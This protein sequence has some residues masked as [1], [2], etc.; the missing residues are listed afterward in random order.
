MISFPQFLLESSI[1][2]LAFYLFYY[3][4]LRKE[5]F[6]Q[7]NRLFLLS[8]PF[9]AIAIPLLNINLQQNTLESTSNS[10]DRML[11]PAVQQVQSVNSFIWQNISQ[12]TAAFSLS[13]GELLLIFYFIGVGI[14]LIR[15]VLGM[16]R[17]FKLI[18]KNKQLK[19]K[20]YTVV[21][22][23]QQFPAA[24][25]FSYIFWN[26]QHIPDDKKLIFEHELVHVRQF[27]SLDVLLMEC[28]VI[29][30]WYNPLIYLYRNALQTTHEYIADQY[31]SQKASSVYQYASLLLQH[32]QDQSCTPLLNTFA[33]LIKKRLVML[34][35]SK[36]KWYRSLKYCWSIPLFGV[37]MLLF[38]FNLVDEIPKNSL[39]NSL[40]AIEHYL[41]DLGD[42]TVLS[43]EKNHPYQPVLEWGGVEFGLTK[44]ANDRSLDFE[45]KTISANAFQQISTQPFLI[46]KLYET[47]PILSFEAVIETSDHKLFSYRNEFSTL[48]EATSKL[49]TDFTLYLK[50]LDS[51]GET[52]YS[53]LSIG[54]TFGLY[55]DQ[56]NQNYFFNQPTYF[57][58]T[59]SDYIK[60]K[61]LQNVGQN[62]Y[63]LE[64]SDKKFQAIKSGNPMKEPF[65]IQS[66][67]LSEFEQL[68]NENFNLVYNNS[69]LLIDS[70]Y[71]MVTNETGTQYKCKDQWN[72]L[73]CNRNFLYEIKQDATVYL[74]IRTKLGDL[75][76]SIISVGN[77]PTLYLEDEQFYSEMQKYTHF[78]NANPQVEKLPTDD[79]QL[80]WGDLSIQLSKESSKKSISGQTEITRSQFLKSLKK[81][82]V[83][84]LVKG[85]LFDQL[86]FNI[87]LHS[88]KMN[89][90]FSVGNLSSSS[91][92]SAYFDNALLKEIEN[93]IQ[94]IDKINLNQIR[95]TDLEQ[96][97]INAT[98]FLK[99]DPIYETRKISKRN[100]YF[101]FHWGLMDVHLTNESQK[102]FKATMEISKTDFQKS[103]TQSPVLTSSKKGVFNKFGFDLSC[104]NEK[105]SV[106]STLNY[107]DDYTN[108]LDVDQVI[109]TVKVGDTFLLKK[110]T[111]NSLEEE[112][113]LKIIITEPTALNLKTEK[114]QDRMVLDWSGF[115]F[116]LR[117]LN[118]GNRTPTKT[119]PITL[120]PYFF[121]S[122]V[123]DQPMLFHK[124][125]LNTIV[126]A[127]VVIKDGEL[128]EHAKTNDWEH[129]DEIISLLEYA[130]EESQISLFFKTKEKNNYILQ[131]R[132]SE[133]LVDETILFG[134]DST[135]IFNHLVQDY[136]KNT[137]KSEQ[138]RMQ[139][140]TKLKLPFSGKKVEVIWGTNTYLMEERNNSFGHRLD[141]YISLNEL[142]AQLNQPVQFKADNKI[143]TPA[144]IHLFGY[145]QTAKE[146][147][148]Y[149]LTNNDNEFIFSTTDKQD[150][151]KNAANSGQIHL[152]FSFKNLDLGKDAVPIGIASISFSFSGSTNDWKPTI[153]TQKFDA[154]G[155][156]FPFQMV[157]RT[158]RHTLVR[159]DTTSKKYDW[160]VKSYQNNPAVDLIHI[161]GFKTHQRVISNSGIT[162]LKKEDI[163][164]QEILNKDALNPMIYPDYYDFGVKY[165][166]LFWRDFKASSFDT[167]I[168]CLEDFKKA[169]GK[170]ELHIDDI[171]HKI[172]QFDL[173]IIDEEGVTTHFVSDKTNRKEI[174]KAIKNATERM[175]FVINRLLIESPD[176]MIQH[177][178]MQFNFYLE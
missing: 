135:Q 177:F 98:I 89:R 39:T 101:H 143:E 136:S 175:T 29:L 62:Q 121:K 75:F 52:H 82:P 63:Y 95:Y 150:I 40:S 58:Y 12:P 1:C 69:C 56:I 129:R 165:I 87:S 49:T 68:R 131:F 96:A 74:V 20:G 13:L 160:M 35:Q 162:K 154:T 81:E 60:S 83:L 117:Q 73:A 109:N 84:G 138:E 30:K 11:Y 51:E 108:S 105:Y 130:C 36:S 48:R 120:S 170:L 99:D 114:Y 153:T 6:F 124:G 176:G 103:I 141:S 79:Y 47:N 147:Y 57:S 157:N 126:E 31:V 32:A 97:P 140:K 15:L 159:M 7:L 100:K 61:D 112:L 169:D 10:F 5:T 14:M 33:A 116:D 88:S 21:E 139:A 110:V 4:A 152:S 78:P 66:L 72:D 55:R 44:Q 151:L 178:P 92:D 37:L 166:S 45:I 77:E 67:S 64:W 43:I 34:G 3:V 42:K 123:C 41:E 86:S 145:N 76:S 137:A 118:T 8:S 91:E 94:D 80:F 9:F 65:D 127:A 90:G 149:V 22:M 172:L 104:N 19:S 134:Q 171:T 168:Y 53:I 173:Y 50:L 148:R 128:V 132:L 167:E 16:V 144:E 17:L 106:L 24:S 38:S 113:M 164:R 161:D 59:I 28:W 26:D 115:D 133:A 25:F 23:D 2:L 107:P 146:H 174:K 122:I 54:E 158:N 125:Q 163:K 142:E 18:R 119:K 93:H 85:Q 102:Q 111:A 27:H 46:K 70:V 71:T 155:Q 156:P